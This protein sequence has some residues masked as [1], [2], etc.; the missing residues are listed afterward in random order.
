MGVI[1]LYLTKPEQTEYQRLRMRSP[2]R[3]TNCNDTEL[4]VLATLRCMLEVTP[5]QRSLLYKLAAQ[6]RTDNLLF[7]NESLAAQMV[8]GNAKLSRARIQYRRN[9]SGFTTWRTNAHLEYVVF[10][11]S[12]PST[13]INVIYIPD[14]REF[15][16][17]FSIGAGLTNNCVLCNTMLTTP[18]CTLCGYRRG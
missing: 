12:V 8:Q 2:L 10:A 11:L 1:M 4:K 5:V 14:L 15:L 6:T 9:Y 13:S 17:R 7:V 18:S 3:Y 16:S